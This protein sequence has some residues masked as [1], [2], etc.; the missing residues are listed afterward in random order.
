MIQRNSSSDRSIKRWRKLVL[1][2]VLA[3]VA[4]AA[5]AGWIVCELNRP[6]GSG[7]KQEIV[8]ERGTSVRAIA[9]ELEELGLIRS[10]NLFVAYVRFKGLAAQLE[11]GSYEIPPTLSM[12]QVIEVLRHG[13]FDVRLTF[14]EGWRR[15]EYLEYLLERLP[16]DSESFR[17]EFIAETDDLE[18]YLFPDTYVVFQD[19]SAEELVSLMKENFEAKYA[20]VAE[21]VAAGSLSREEAVTLASLI[22]R[23]A[24]QPEEQAVIAGIFLKRLELGMSLGACATVQYALGYQPPEAVGGKGSWWKSS[25]T[26]PDTEVNSPYN[27]YKHTGLPP[28][29]ICSPGLAALKAAASPQASEYLY[30]LHD[31]DGGIHYARTLTEHNQNVARY[32]K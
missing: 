10:A 12:L 16:V 22:E 18:G 15:E 13:T 25:I 30:Y 31:A 8:I 11:A 7:S 17:T 1:F 9:A 23:E 5:A 6:A 32:L 24:R 26:I 2:L 14:L 28:G 4:A 19:I 3:I 21:A 20:E 27:T 29:P